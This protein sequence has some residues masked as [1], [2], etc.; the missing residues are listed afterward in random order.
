MTREI[1]ASMPSDDA[2]VRRY[3][4]TMRRATT[5][6][7]YGGLFVRYPLPFIVFVSLTHFQ[8]WATRQMFLNSGMSPETIRKNCVIFVVTNHKS[9]Y[10]S[11][12]F[13]GHI[14]YEPRDPTR[15]REAEPPC[16]FEVHWTNENE[17]SFCMMAGSCRL[18]NP[19]GGNLFTQVPQ[20]LYVIRQCCLAG[21]FHP[22]KAQV[23]LELLVNTLLIFRDPGGIL[24]EFKQDNFTEWDLMDEPDDKYPRWESLIGP[25]VNNL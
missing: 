22:L 6:L 3:R 23:R 10:N 12:L 8:D 16:H 21:D 11:S 5:L 1:L 18:E 2:S 7:G 19:I 4:W 24:N 20:W 13:L 17:D 14:N 9:L 25:V 15:D